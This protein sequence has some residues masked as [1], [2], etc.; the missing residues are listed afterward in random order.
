M[1]RERHLIDR[2]TFFGGSVAAMAYTAAGAWAQ[3]PAAI[4]SDQY[5]P[6]SEEQR[7]AD[8][9]TANRILADQHVLDSYG[10]VTVRSFRNPK[11]FLMSGNR[12]PALVTAEDIMEFDENSLPVDQRGRRVYNERFIHGEIFRARPDVVAVVHSHA[13]DVLPFTVTD[14]VPL[15]AL[16]HMAHFIGSEP[17]PVFDLEEVEG[18]N[19]NMLVL[20]SKSGEA[21]AKKLGDRNVVLM[22]G[23]GMTVVGP[24]IR[25]ATYNAV[26]TQLNARVEMDALKLGRPKFMNEFEVKRV[27]QINRAWEAW[28]DRA[29]G[30]R[31]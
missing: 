22:R 21:L 28:A 29:K 9:V 15:K 12:A 6:D 19:N 24:N 11:H 27:G 13:P 5:P 23:H 3:A 20:N 14:D 31:S 10:H 17:V 18:P 26:Y 25:R 7:I 8:L 4:P 16:I 2:R 1:R 30:P